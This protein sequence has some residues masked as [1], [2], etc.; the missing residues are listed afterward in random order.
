M[1][2][3]VQFKG[4]N[5]FRRFRLKSLRNTVSAVSFDRLMKNYSDIKRVVQLISSRRRADI[6]AAD[7]LPCIFL[8]ANSKDRIIDLCIFLDII[9]T[10]CSRCRARGG[11]KHEAT[12]KAFD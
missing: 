8:Y 10:Y 3:M 11:E 2:I 9:Y 4:I 5:I 1:V 12:L 6:I 7:G